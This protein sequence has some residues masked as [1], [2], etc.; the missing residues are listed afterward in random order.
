MA[1]Y[2]K[3]FFLALCEVIEANASLTFIDFYYNLSN[4]SDIFCVRLLCVFIVEWEVIV[5]KLTLEVEFSDSNLNQICHN[6][7]IL[8]S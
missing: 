8:F 2:I 6:Q 7:C 5:L 3:I 4:E 1:T